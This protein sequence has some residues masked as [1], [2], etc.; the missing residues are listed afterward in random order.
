ML[1]LLWLEGWRELQGQQRLQAVAVGWRCALS[2]GRL[3][4]VSAI[5]E[6]LALLDEALDDGLVEFGG[7]QCVL[8]FE[9]RPH[10]RWPE[11]DGEIVGGHQCGLA[12]LTNPG[13]GRT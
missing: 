13:G 9:I 11:T 6:I 2:A 3:G 10:E 8:V 7:G 5:E 4:H 1:D 12:M